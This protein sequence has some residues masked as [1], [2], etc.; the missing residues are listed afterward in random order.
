[1]LNRFETFTLLINRINRN[2]R[3]IKIQEMA[4]YGLR[5]IHV[6]CLYYLRTI[7]GLTA[8][9]LCDRCAE[10]KATISRAL[11]FLEQEGYLVNSRRYKSTLTL[12]EKGVAVG[13]EIVGKIAAVL[14]AISDGLT[15]EEREAF[16]RSLTII[17]D[18]L[19]AVAENGKE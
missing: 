11:D 12:T 5:S 2:I 9:D 10:D 6:S 8:K 4:S 19:D 3:K 15:A 14:D 13:D 7:D 16:Y 1:M 18:R 17:S